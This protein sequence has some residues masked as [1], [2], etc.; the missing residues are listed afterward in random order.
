MRHGFT[1]VSAA[2]TTAR[3]W[4]RRRPHSARVISQDGVTTTYPASTQTFRL[5]DPG[6]GPPLGGG[7]EGWVSDSAAIFAEVWFMEMKA[8]SEERAAASAS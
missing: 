2:P 3:A 5:R 6:L 1:A 7:V 4:K 8:N